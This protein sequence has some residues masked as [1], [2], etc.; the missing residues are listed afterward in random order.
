MASKSLCED[1][2]IF[3]NIQNESGNEDF[4]T[5]FVCFLLFSE[6]NMQEVI[7]VFSCSPARV[8]GKLLGNFQSTFSDSSKQNHVYGAEL[9]TLWL[10]IAGLLVAP[11]AIQKFTVLRLNTWIA[12]ALS[13]YSAN[14]SYQKGILCRSGTWFA[15]LSFSITLKAA[16]M[17]TALWYSKEQQVNFSFLCWLLL[18]ILVWLIS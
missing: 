16:L 11:F 14:S 7:L 13:P 17:V 9:P 15:F 4:V 5:G 1:G 18:R 6:I 8:K 12:L 10:D 2:F 3:C